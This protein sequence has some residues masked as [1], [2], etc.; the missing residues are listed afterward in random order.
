M[1]KSERKGGLSVGP[2]NL[3]PKAK[4]LYGALLY[5]SIN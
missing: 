1:I 2:T 4:I 3:G 5:V